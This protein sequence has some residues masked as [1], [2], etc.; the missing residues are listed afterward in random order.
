MDIV[1]VIARVS[2]CRVQKY[3]IQRMLRKDVTKKISGKREHSDLHWKNWNFPPFCWSF[4][5][6]EIVYNCWNKCFISI[7]LKRENWWSILEEIKLREL[8]R[9]NQLTSW[10]AWS[11][12][13]IDLTLQAMSQTLSQ[14]TLCWAQFKLPRSWTWVLCLNICLS[15]K[16]L[17]AEL[18]KCFPH[19]LSTS[20]LSWQTMRLLSKWISYHLSMK[21][22]EILKKTQLRNYT[23][24][25]KGLI[26]L[27]HKKDVESFHFLF[28]SFLPHP[29]FLYF[30]LGDFYFCLSH[31]ILSDVLLPRLDSSSGKL[32][33]SCTKVNL[34]APS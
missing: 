8:F 31:I 21:I 13:Q 26:Y 29:V 12:I 2:T 22:C 24:S 25:K 16:Q 19:F 33:P 9:P 4:L 11:L 3:K 5:C 34:Q 6:P 10:M 32:L 14:L 15:L 18:P 30:Y 1:P 28:Q 27:H 7:I 23:L 20:C 17:M